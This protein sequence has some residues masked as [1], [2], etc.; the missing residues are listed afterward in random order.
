MP[1]CVVDVDEV[2]T[3]LT[4]AELVR[5]LWESD[6]RIA[7]KQHGETGIS[8]TPDTL[9]DGDEHVITERLLGIIGLDPSA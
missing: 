8:M 4:G 3:G 9:S 1:R 2:I 7:V 6:P 5:R